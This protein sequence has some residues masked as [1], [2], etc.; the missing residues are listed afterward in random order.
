MAA[1]PISAAE[2]VKAFK[3]RPLVQT[4]KPG[5]LKYKDD[6]GNEKERDG[7][8]VKDV[9]LSEEHVLAAVK[10]GDTVVVVTLDGKRHEA[11]A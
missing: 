6:A 9:S 1:T 7:F 10:R 5:K 4:A 11:R 3:T 8:I 2:A